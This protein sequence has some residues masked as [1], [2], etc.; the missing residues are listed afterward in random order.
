M[1]IEQR[2]SLLGNPSSKWLSNKG[3]D[4]TFYF[5]LFLWFSIVIGYLFWIVFTREAFEQGGIF[6]S[7]KVV[8]GQDGSV[9]LLGDSL[10]N[11]P[12][13]YYDLMGKMR[14]RSSYSFGFTNCGIGGD[15]I[16]D[17]RSRLPKLITNIRYTTNVNRVV[18]S[19]RENKLSRVMVILFWDSDISDID[20]SDMSE[21]EI[22]VLRYK[23]NGIVRDVIQQVLNAGA[24]MA[25]SG[26]EVLGDTQKTSMLN[27]YRDINIAI[28]NSF[29]MEYIDMRTAFLNEINAGYSPTEGDGEHPNN[30]GSAVIAKLFVEAQHKWKFFVNTTSIQ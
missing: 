7:N 19:V 23:Y 10:I 12:C 28:A 5:S 24:Y 22:S 17:I 2:E 9:V 13:I 30:H 25:I 1:E 4:L 20:E 3:K 29:D 27:A 15:T 14:N 18:S 11:N 16:S 8:P 26:P 21:E 6:F